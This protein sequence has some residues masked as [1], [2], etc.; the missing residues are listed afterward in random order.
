MTRHIS[1]GATSSFALSSTQSPRRGSE[2]NAEPLGLFLVQNP[3]EPIADLILVHGLGGS[4][5]KTWSWKRNPDLFWPAWLKDEVDLS[6]IRIFS[7]GYN[8]NFAG[9]NSVYSI[10]DFAKSLL[11]HMSTYSQDGERPIGTHPIIFVAHS[12]GGLVVKKAYVIGRGNSQYSQMV[13]RV[14]AFMFMS[15]PHKGSFHA[16][17][18][19]SL[20]SASPKNSQKIYVAELDVNST[21]LQDLNEQFRVI[22]DGLHIVSFYETLLTKM[23]PTKILMVG[24]ESGVLNYP[25]E[26]SSPL[27]ADHHDVAKFSSP[28]D[29]NYI[30]VI[31]LLRQLVQKLSP[32][33]DTMRRVSKL[34]HVKKLE[35][36]LGIND[37]PEEGLTHH[38]N[39]SMHGSGKWLQARTAFRHWFEDHQ[40]S[41]P[42]FW[43][44]GHPGTGKSTLASIT[45]DYLHGR[46]SERSCQYH[47]FS[48]GEPRKKSTEYALRMLAFQIALTNDDLASRLVR[49]HDEAGVIFTTQ[50]LHALWESLFEAI[51]L[52]VDFGHTLYWVL[53]ALD[54]SDAPMKLVKLLTRT[55]SRSRL[56][57][58]LLSR[59]TN[60]LSNLAFS[61]QH[62]IK[63]D[64]ISVADTR[65][66]IRTYVR[67]VV[68]EALPNDRTLQRNI[69][70]E[71]L[72]KSE[73][74]FLWARLSLKTLR[75]SWHTEEDMRRALTD[76]PKGMEPLYARMINLVQ[77]QSQRSQDIAKSILTWAVCCYR[78]M[79]LAEL[80]AALE[81]E[82]GT[83]VSLEDTIHQVC[84]HFIRIDQSVVS[85]I[86]AT[87]RKFLLNGAEGT[88][89]FIA[90]GSGHEL[91]ATICVKYLSREH[92]K[93]LFSQM[94]ENTSTKM[95]TDRLLPLYETHPFLRYAKDYWAFH[96]S[97][98]TV[99]SNQLIA[100]L[101]VFFDKY[102]LSWIH[103]I[104][105]SHSLI[106]LTRAAHYIKTFLRRQKTK[107]STDPPKSLRAEEK[108]NANE[109][110]RFLQHWAVDLIR[111]V[112]KFGSNLLQNPS[113]IYRHI[114]PLCPY[115]SII[116]QTYGT[117]EKPML[118]VKGISSGEWDDSLARLSVGEGLTASKV[119]CAGA[120]F[121]TLIATNGTLIVWSAETCEQLQRLEHKEWVTQ[122]AVNKTGTLVASA[123]RFTFRVWQLSTGKEIYRFSKPTQARTMDLQFG[124]SDSEIFVGY[125][126][127][128]V[129][130]YDLEDSRETWRF[131][132][133]ETNEV[134]HSCPRLLVLSPD[135][136]KVAIAYRGHPVLVWD[137]NGPSTQQ[138]KKCIRDEDI[139]KE[140]E[141]AWNAPEVVRW[142]PDSTS[143]LVLYQDTVLVDWRV[144]EDQRYPHGHI[145]AREMALNR[146]GTLLLTSNH[147]GTLSVW[148]HPKFNLVYRLLYDEFVRDLAFSPD[149]QRIYDTRG[150]L[151]NVWEPDALI[152]S[153]DIERDEA[154]SAGT[155]FT[156][157]PVFSRD[158]NNRSQ[159]TAV[160]C[161]GNDDYYCCGK[162]D[163]TVTIHDMDDGKK[164]R[165]VY[166]HSSSGAIIALA[167]SPSGRF[168]VSGDD[169][170]RLVAK[171]L[172]IKEAGKWAVFPLFDFRIDE[173][174][175]Q[176]L[177]SPDEDIVLI[178]TAST[179][180]TF[181]IRTKE[182]VCLKRW[183]STSGRK[184][185]N[186]PIHKNN[187]IWL[188]P[189]EL[190]IHEWSSLE[191][192]ATRQ[193]SI[194]RD[195]V[196]AESDA[197]R[198]ILKE[199][200]SL[201]LERSP[202]N[203]ESLERVHTVAQTSDSQ[204]ILCETLPDTG[205]ARSNSTQGLML[206]MLLI[207]DLKVHRP[208]PVRR[209]HLLDLATNVQRFLGCVHD[210]AIFLDHQNWLC[211]WEIDWPQSVIKQHFFLPKDWLSNSY[212]QLA[213]L[214][215]QGTFLCPKNG[216]VAIVRY[217][218]R[219]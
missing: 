141:E 75:Q 144:L 151:C 70:E 137:V 153:E 210:R 16:N 174:V 82:F 54:E 27:N 11:L 155:S 117:Q 12:M 205:H 146:D 10:M 15:T 6:N 53:D 26:T 179:D 39:R 140:K 190:H 9:Q 31:S 159:I 84:G 124:S 194:I 145:E 59:P 103:S 80:E 90:P 126:D 128:R 79:R 134:L 118:S 33:P 203:S 48:E 63:Y 112:G 109:D 204:Y 108:T 106:R 125:D 99:D 76:V 29:P 177:F 201:S 123:G 45:I 61:Q 25:Q 120:Y 135:A 216:E 77:E 105:A 176:F 192:A 30:L 143:L 111:V 58:F 19:N 40:E 51:I 18:L 4:S 68:Q 69:I 147:N 50:K 209:R 97:R 7:F 60:E 55:R 208:D 129:V 191:R 38:R 158:D 100:C 152:Q 200:F 207:S 46:F 136:T 78:P 206:H 56:K 57:M 73:G 66:D 107:S 154:S 94:P 35:V 36:I 127:C 133:E 187:L 3:P 161:D 139:D 93:R 67:T 116:F 72:H 98:S 88:P 211:T 89:P 47:F 164:L 74:S 183:S 14:R 131:V 202:S 150:S 71:V 169:S 65:E 102:A 168:I 43:L 189:C 156:L 166:T 215:K 195:D 171:R 193:T 24:K 148:T 13:S 113:T 115:N 198:S 8:A 85:L 23:G 180:R 157:E 104:A 199:T 42:I 5:L 181:N 170:G 86:H 142:H 28:D 62:C 212:L 138:P 186:H 91:L 21:T 188:D 149:G 17:M 130:H 185:I 218:N 196:P 178:T 167:W 197:V 163:G 162:D 182:I 172:G 217:G 92:W 96:T 173:T 20:L 119:A 122:I 95:R 81:P 110:L 34:E 219:L 101:R 22:C 121:V 213:S 114:I 175:E 32:R 160:A 64:S 165:K 184:W 37:S 44:S 2:P 1:A 83:F 41:R 52:K 132:A 214:N 49:L 87:A